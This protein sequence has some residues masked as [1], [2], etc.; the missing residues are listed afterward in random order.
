[1]LKLMSIA[2][3]L[4]LLTVSA[5]VVSSTC[6]AEGRSFEECRELAI[7][8]GVPPR[9]ANSNTVERQYLR[10]KAAGTALHPRGQIA[11]CMSGRS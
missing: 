10:Y 6:K 2:A 7:A 5:L 3:V 11:R 8:H 9:S 1:M 4:G